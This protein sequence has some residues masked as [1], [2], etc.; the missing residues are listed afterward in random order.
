M[1]HIVM[2]SG[3]IGSWAAAK[4]VV[5][6]HG[7]DDVTLLFSDTLIED[8]DLYRFLNEA[9]ADIG[10]PITRIADGRTPW[11]VFEDERF[12]GNSRVD[13]C[14]KI[15][16]RQLID[17]WRNANCDP[18]DT[19]CYVGIDW[20]ESHRLERLLP[21][22]APW[23][24][25]APLCA[26]PY[27]LK[28]ELLE[29]LDAVGI[30]PP[31]L[32]SMGFAHNNCGG[33]CI[34]AGQRQFKLLLENFPERYAEHEAN[35][36]RVMTITGSPWGVMRDRRGGTSK[37]LTMR[38]FRERCERREETEAGDLAAGCGCALD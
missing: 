33:F 16:K 11:Q 6:K 13:P 20:T 32:Y 7:K 21:R 17:D 18:A 8:E 15:L 34:K 9:S 23:K 14:S 24:Y 38:E 12:I 2:F 4:R 28:M 36:A 10:I 35:E 5:A 3:G 22:V 30:K 31:R 27:K 26:P 1:K 37:P 19:V 25:E 29:E